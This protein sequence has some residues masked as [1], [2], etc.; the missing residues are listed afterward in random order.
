MSYEV[1]GFKLGTLTAASDLTAKQFCFA[2]VSGV[3][4]ADLALAADKAIGIIQNKPAINTAVEL[5]VNGVSKV[6]A[7]AAVTAGAAVGPDAT[8]RA[9][10][11]PTNIVA[12]ALETATAA[13]QLIAVLILAKS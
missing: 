10:S 6:L 13:G 9:I 8:S 1:P 11:A 3:N 4:Q 5:M 2:K 7:G 12:V